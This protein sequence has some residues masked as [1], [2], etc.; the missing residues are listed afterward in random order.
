MTGTE[1]G[2]KM[3]DSAGQRLPLTGTDKLELIRG[4]VVATAIVILPKFP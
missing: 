3:S 1:V 2:K 4:E